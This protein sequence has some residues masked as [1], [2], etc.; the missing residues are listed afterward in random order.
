MKNKYCLPIVKKSK[1]DVLLMIDEHLDNYGFFEIWLD[2]IEELDKEFLRELMDKFSG[3]LVFTLRRKD[4]VKPMMDTQ[5]MSGIINF[6]YQK[7][8]LL[9]LD[10][11][12][13]NEID[14]VISLKMQNQLILSFHDYS[15]TPEDIYLDKIV[16]KMRLFRPGILKISTMCNE[17]SDALRLIKHKR[18]MI[19]DDKKHIVLGMGEH[20]KITRVFGA[21]WGNELIFIPEN[22]AEETAPG[23]INRPD[24]DKI[25]QRIDSARK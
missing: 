4:P 13:I 9:D 11:T 3:R 20:G 23:Q 22:Q 5:R 17:P 25:M 10:L 24:F 21:I 8:C 19:V 16:A 15:R 6:L 7:K 14:L 18:D 12:Q 2:Y 1:L